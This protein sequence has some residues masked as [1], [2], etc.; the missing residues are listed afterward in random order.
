MKKPTT[1]QIACIIALAVLIAMSYIK[2]ENAP[3]LHPI[4]LID[5]PVYTED[6]L[7]AIPGSKDSLVIYGGVPKGIVWIGEHSKILGTGD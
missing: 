6:H 2:G 4:G 1:T 5:S 3:L 7:E